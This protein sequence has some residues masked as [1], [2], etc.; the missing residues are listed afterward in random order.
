M[1]DLV[2]R[3][4]QNDRPARWRPLLVLL[5][6]LIGAPPAAGTVLEGN[7]HATDHREAGPAQERQLIEALDAL[8]DNRPDEARRILERL[9]AAHPRFRLAQLVYADL[10]QAR[11]RPLQAFGQGAPRERLADL[12]AEA[13]VRWAHYV[14]PPPPDSV[15]RAVVQ[16]DR[17][18]P[19]V[20]VIELNRNRLYVLD[21]RQPVPTLVGDY[22]ISMG[23]KGPAKL[24][25]GDKRTPIGVYHVTAHLSAS[26]LPDFYG[27][28]AF[29]I[30]YPND[31]DRRQGRTGSGI[32]LH[33]APSDTY[34]RPPRASD[35]CVVLS[36][37]DFE[38]LGRYVE[39]GRTPVV[40]TPEIRWLDRAAW[41][42]QRQQLLGL[43]ETWRRDWESRDADRYLRHY[44]PDF[45]GR[46][47]DLAAW[48]AYK[49]RVNAGK[50]FIRVELKEINL[51]H[52][53]GEKDLL[54]ATFR[55]HYRSDNHESTSR[56]RL[57]W[58]RDA[59]GRWRILYEGPA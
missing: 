38:H 32:W 19:Y 48:R 26:R 2:E 55:Q 15:P 10:L 59:S 52:Y 1:G 17:S 46:G 18:H 39:S 53:P 20:L 50:K 23:K 6:A 31:W 4:A 43:L 27:A 33:G 34:S 5:A 58:R 42:A 37:P 28:G 45:R 49:R 36:N 35:G 12:D 44:H 14:S 8:R 3:P 54:V 22:Y 51:F 11:V 57:Y 24:K 13:R 40:I 7:R 9:L 56:K 21:N 41:Q 29:P 16:V 25:R 30:N 47:M